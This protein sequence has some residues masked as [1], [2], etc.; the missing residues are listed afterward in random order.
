MCVC[1]SSMTFLCGFSPG[2]D[3]RLEKSHGHS[4]KFL[5][6][7]PACD[8]KISCNMRKGDGLFTVAKGS[9]NLSHAEDC[10]TTPQRVCAKDVS[11][12]YYSLHTCIF[13]IRSEG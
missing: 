7:H 5:C 9:L 6:H 13:G 12:R 11:L 1:V 2:K 3:V 4:F 8:F 10:F